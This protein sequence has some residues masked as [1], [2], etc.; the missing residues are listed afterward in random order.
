MCIP[1]PLDVPVLTS[2][3]LGLGTAREILCPYTGDDAA[4]EA[5]RDPIPI[6][7]RTGEAD[8]WLRVE[9]A[10]GSNLFIPFAAIAEVRLEGVR[11]AVTAED[12]ERRG[13]DTPPPGVELTNA[14]AA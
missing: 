13:W 14:S 6:Q 1:V 7:E 9:R 4:P 11:L 10:D 2:D 8:L 12:S 3:S 5:L